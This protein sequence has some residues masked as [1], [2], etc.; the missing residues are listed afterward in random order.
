MSKGK[1]TGGKDFEK[2][3]PGGKGRPLIPPDVKAA[4][5]L[6]ADDFTIALYVAGKLNFKEIQFA[7]NDPTEPGMNALA[8]RWWAKA[9][10]GSLEHAKA[11]VERLGS[12]VPKH[13]ELTGAEGTPLVP[14]LDS[15]Q[16]DALTVAIVHLQKFVKEKTSC[17][18]T[19]TAPPSPEP[20]PPSQGQLLASSSGTRS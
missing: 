7:A 19:P 17:S 14:A 18:S 5:K 16:G 10:N 13:V 9:L 1:K 2:G 15:F 3:N 20:L 12:V 6:F 11:I 4:R 8:L